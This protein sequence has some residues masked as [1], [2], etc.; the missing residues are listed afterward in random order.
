M[1]FVST[2]PVCYTE[3]EMAFPLIASLVV[4]AD[5][6]TKF[7]IRTNLDLRQSIPEDGLVRLTYVRNTG[8]AFGLLANQTF[9]IVLTTAVGIAVILLYYSYPPL[10]RLP[11]RVGLGLLL[12]GSV[13]NL[14]DRLRFG[15][16]TDFIDLRVWPVF[17]L[18]DSAIV[19]GVAILTYF[20]I[21]RAMR[22]G[23]PV[24]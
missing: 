1:L 3:K 20:L 8:A 14:V 23:H 4:I 19:V 12:G 10:N 24:G 13:G 6:L 2:G 18:A 16:V 17:N 5:Q 7:L 11:V 22:E 15:Y 9:L 21:F